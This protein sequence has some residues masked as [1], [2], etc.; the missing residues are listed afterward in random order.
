MEADYR[1]EHDNEEARIVT[2]AGTFHLSPELFA[3]YLENAHLKEYDYEQYWEQRSIGFILARATLPQSF[4]AREKELL[5]KWPTDDL[6][7]KVVEWVARE[8]IIPT[9][10]LERDMA[11]SR[12]GDIWNRLTPE[13]KDLMARERL[14]LYF[15]NNSTNEDLTWLEHKACGSSTGFFFGN[16]FMTGLEADPEWQEQARAGRDKRLEEISSAENSSALA[17]YIYGSKA[18]PLPPDTSLKF[19][20]KSIGLRHFRSRYPSQDL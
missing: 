15:S 8:R 18:P 1:I 10:Y 17:L 7:R 2:N 9:D 13:I 14:F 19:R 20:E 16:P 4:P 12:T 6:D 5:N 3:A 11:T